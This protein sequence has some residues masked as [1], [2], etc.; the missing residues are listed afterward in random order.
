MFLFI[1]NVSLISSQTIYTAVG[2]FPGP[3]GYTGD[4][5]P[6]TSARLDYPSDLKFDKTGNLY[7][8]EFTN[9]IIRKVNTSGIITTIAGNGYM[10]GTGN[11]GFSGDGG[12]ATAAELWGPTGIACDTFGNIYI[13]DVNNNIIR[14]VNTSGTINTIVGNFSYL[15]G[16]SG[17]GGQ[18]TNA[19]VNG[20]YWVATDISGNVYFT[21]VGNNV[22]R[23]VDTSGII[24]PFAGNYSYGGGYS[25]D[26][27]PSTAAELSVPEAIAFS[28]SGNLYIADGANQVIRMVNSSGTISTIAGNGIYGYSGDGGQ[29]TAAE[30]SPYGIAF[31]VSGSLYISDADA[32]VIRKIDNSGIITTVAGYGWHLGYSGDGGLATLAKMNLNNGITLDVSGNLFIADQGNNVVR[33]VKN[34][35]TSIKQPIASNNISV[36]PNPSNG[37]FTLEYGLPTTESGKIVLYNEFGE[38]V[39]EYQ[40]DAGKNKMNITNNNLSNGI[41]FYQVFVNNKGSKRG[42]LIITK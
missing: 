3:H 14:K 32:D 40:L 16:Y 20:P 19:E 1:F 7:I 8:A 34:I 31:D 24:E 26:G 29:A 5:G 11:G 17:D 4:G 36:Y 18:A 21:D 37:S 13:A 6:A 35:S 30:F 25:G 10:A 41:Y 15:P 42:K 39:G 2:F 33:V 27:G 9:N 38:K 28:P 22:I 23:K 12:P